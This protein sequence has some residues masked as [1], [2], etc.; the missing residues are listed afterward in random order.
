MANIADNGFTELSENRV[1]RA[2]G[3]HTLGCASNFKIDSMLYDALF[4]VGVSFV[5]CI[6]YQSGGQGTNF[7]VIPESSEPLDVRF[8]AKPGGLPL[9]IVAMA[10]LRGCD[11]FGLR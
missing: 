9:G 8:P 6:F 3:L 4:H 2:Y 1:C 11:G 7:V 10:L 5:G